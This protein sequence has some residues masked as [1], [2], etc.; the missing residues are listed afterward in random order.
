MASRNKESL[1]E[2]SFLHRNN[3]QSASPSAIDSSHRLV[4]PKIQ[5]LSLRDRLAFARTMARDTGL[6][7]HIV[8]RRCGSVGHLWY[9]P[10]SEKWIKV[11]NNISSKARKVSFAFPKPKVPSFCFFGVLP[12]RESPASRL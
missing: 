5:I 4:F 7:F 8:F 11:S 3:S 9:R 1:G 10:A 12:T 6:S 2:L